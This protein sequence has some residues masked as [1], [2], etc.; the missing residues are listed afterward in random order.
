ML[1]HGGKLRAAAA[2]YDIPV[3]DWLDL[4]TGINPQGWP[5]PALPPEAWQRLPEGDDGL[6]QAMA[7][8][9]GNPDGLPTAGSQAAL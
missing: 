5:V 6:E 7:A 2:H 1:E 9:Y 4:S 8:Y 3:A